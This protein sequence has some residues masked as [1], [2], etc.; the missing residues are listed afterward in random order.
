M[1]LE[2]MDY[3][4]I[5]DAAGWK[6]DSRLTT[7]VQHQNMKEVGDAIPMAEG[8]EWR[9]HQRQPLSC[10][11]DIWVISWTKEEGKMEVGVGYDSNRV[12]EAMAK[13]LVE[14]LVAVLEG[15]KREPAREVREF[16][17]ETFVP[18]AV[19]PRTMSKGKV[20]GRTY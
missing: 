16:L 1:M 2:A 12:S 6:R 9:F 3:G 19:S 14:S 17:P 18:R 20:L 5:C 10:E 15:M 11:F 4:D 8:E 7:V 13:E